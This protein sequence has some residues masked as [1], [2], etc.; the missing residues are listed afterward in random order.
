MI[1]LSDD[2]R[3]Y[4]MDSDGTKIV[5]QIFNGVLAGDKVEAEYAEKNPKTDTVNEDVVT[6][7]RSEEDE[8][9][10]KCL[11]ELQR[12]REVDDLGSRWSAC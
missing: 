4:V 7:E 9:P 12:Q 1:D 5:G 11:A 10:I 6:L 8:A 2:L 3:Y